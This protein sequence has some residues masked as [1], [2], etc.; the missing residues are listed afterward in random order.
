[1]NISDEHVPL[2]REVIETRVF[3]MDVRR[4]ELLRQAEDARFVA[5]QRELR[6]EALRIGGEIASLRV[7]QSEL[8]G[9]GSEDWLQ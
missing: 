3:D 8:A 1:M 6:S 4:T 2:L 5:S 9:G 7:V